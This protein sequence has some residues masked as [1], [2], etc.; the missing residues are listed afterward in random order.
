MLVWGI[1]A[2]VISAC[3]WFLYGS[4]KAWCKSGSFSSFFE[5]RKEIFREFMHRVI[6]Y[7]TEDYWHPQ[8]LPEDSRTLKRCIFP[9]ISF[10]LKMYSSRIV[11][12]EIRWSFT[13]YLPLSL[14]SYLP[15]YLPFFLPFSCPFTYFFTYPF[16]SNSKVCSFHQSIDLWPGALRPLLFIFFTIFG[17]PLTVHPHHNALTHDGSPMCS[18]AM[19][20]LSSRLSCDFL[21]PS[22][23]LFAFCS[24]P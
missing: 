12:L 17:F 18:S 7:K 13:L 10:V 21:F 11:T 23:T 3:Y 5:N 24:R 20:V 22:R 16:T 15:F 8:K 6:M 19:S 14:H 4:P 2:T 9:G 1:L